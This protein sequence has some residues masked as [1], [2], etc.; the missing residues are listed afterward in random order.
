M[1]KKY[2]GRKELREKGV[3]LSSET[4]HDLLFYVWRAFD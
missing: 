3:M 1:Y 2:R 4:L